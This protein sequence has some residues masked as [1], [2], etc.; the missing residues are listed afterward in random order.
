MFLGFLVRVNKTSFHGN[1]LK[2][3]YF[4]HLNF[5]ILKKDDCS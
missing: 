2:L 1:I 5:E 3:K 4:K